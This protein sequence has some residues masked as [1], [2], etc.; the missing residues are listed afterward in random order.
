MLPFP[1]FPLPTLQALE[2]DKL[3]A[4][5][6]VNMRKALERQGAQSLIQILRKRVGGSGAL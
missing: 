6:A 3:L 5:H 2:W 1:P 4:R